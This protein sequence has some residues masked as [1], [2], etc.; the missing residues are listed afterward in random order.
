MS[1]A[2][3]LPTSV[4]PSVPASFMTDSA[5]VR[6]IMASVS[7]LEP[8]PGGKFPHHGRRKP[9]CLLVFEP[10][11]APS[12]PSC[13]SPWPVWPAPWPFPPSTNERDFDR[14]IAVGDQAVADER[15][16]QAIEAYSGAIARNPE[17]MLAH[18]KRGVGLPLPEPARCRA[19]RPAPRDRARPQRAARDRDARRRERPP[20]PRRPRHRAVRG[21]HRARRTQRARPLQAWT[22]PL[23]RWPAP[24][25]RR[26]VETGA[27]LSIHRSARPTT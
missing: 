14:L 19:P 20:R 12:S 21:V 16:F 1:T 25:R 27:R 26:A 3:R 24:E 15:P 10:C 18:L 17:S 22:R 13:S 5:I 4:H 8:V 7:R 6:T 11:E 23:P 9:L 2:S